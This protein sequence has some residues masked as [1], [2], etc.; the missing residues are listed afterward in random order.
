MID[1][2]DIS[3]TGF[4]LR[5]QLT[6][7]AGFSS[8]KINGK[9]RAGDSISIILDNINQLIVDYQPLE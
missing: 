4:Y 6:E 7:Q 2:L 5:L 1:V 8:A 3:T 9:E